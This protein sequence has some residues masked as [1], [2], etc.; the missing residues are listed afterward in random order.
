MNLCFG[1]RWISPVT[2]KPVT[3]LHFSSFVNRVRV[4]AWSGYIAGS[5]S[6]KIKPKIGKRY[7]CF[8]NDIVNSWKV[9]LTYLGNERWSHDTENINGEYTPIVHEV[10]T[11]LWGR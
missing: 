9:E 2:N 6:K 1:A 8:A 11:D 4:R 7:L 3:A 10:I 5:N